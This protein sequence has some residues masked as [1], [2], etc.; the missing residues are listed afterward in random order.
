MGIFVFLKG[1]VMPTGQA[2][3]KKK[4]TIV[5]YHYVRNLKSSNYPNIKG[6]SVEAF[7]NQ[8]QFFKKKY[9]FIKV[10]D[11]VEI[12]N[13]NLKKELPDNPCIL[14]FD[15][16]YIDHFQNVFPI[17]K[18]ENIQGCFFPPAR[19]I[20]QNKV[21][22]VNKIH[23]ILERTVMKVDELIK[24]VFSMLS[25]VRKDYNLRDNNYYYDK[26][27]VPS[28]FDSAKVIF[29]KRL[30]QVELDQKLRKLLIDRLF[31]KYVS[32][33]E[34]SF[35]KS[36][37]MNV[38][39]LKFMN[40]NGMYIGSHGYNHCWLDRLSKKEQEIE[41]DRSLQFLK[42]I[43]ATTK[44]WVMCYPYGSYNSSLIKI[45]KKRGCALGLTTIVDS[46]YLIKSNAF[47]LGRF[48]TNDF[49]K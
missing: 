11:C 9:N 18:K 19:A 14:T 36:L 27:A 4:V 21:L 24:E 44:N 7:E 28:R 15:D 2:L 43:G 33:D 8:I 17:L 31:L 39:Q 22:D 42:L 34:K 16:G 32:S 25:E 6:L 35:A 45:L 3:S 23:F 29:I 48:D 12:L 38:N 37:Y 1:M 30:L 5:M 40:D 13:N 26:L 20:L 10:A 46:A 41:V 47:T 49:P